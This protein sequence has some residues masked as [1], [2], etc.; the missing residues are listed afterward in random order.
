VT[1]TCFNFLFYSTIEIE[2]VF[3]GLS[4]LYEY[5]KCMFLGEIPLYKEKCQKAHYFDEMTHDEASFQYHTETFNIVCI[6]IFIELVNYSSIALIYRRP[7]RLNTAEHS[8]KFYKLGE[9]VF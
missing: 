1:L 4:M 9:F 6:C 5:E 3:D 2:T 7:D 8:S